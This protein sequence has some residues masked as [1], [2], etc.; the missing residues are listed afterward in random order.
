M[1]EGANRWAGVHRLDAAPLYR[2]VLE[3]GSADPRYHAV[4]NEGVPG[5]FGAAANAAGDIF[6]GPFE[7]VT[8]EQWAN[9]IAGKGTEVSG[10]MAL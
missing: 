5:P 10:G 7:E 3:K 4:R 1:W 6:P 2:L 8:D 9:S